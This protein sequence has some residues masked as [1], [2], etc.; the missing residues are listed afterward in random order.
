MGLRNR[1][2]TAA[3]AGA[4]ALGMVAGTAATATAHSGGSGGSGG[5]HDPDGQPDTRLSGRDRA[6]LRH[7]AEGA[8][9]E[10]A[11]GLFAAAAAV[12][13][14]VQALGAKIAADHTGELATV[15][16]L[17]AAYGVSLPGDMTSAQHDRLLQVA[18][19]PGLSFD[20]EYTELEVKVHRRNIAAFRSEARRG[21]N[22]D[23]QA[24]ARETIP[25]LKEH[26][27]AARAAN[28]VV[29]RQEHNTERP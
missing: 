27:D 14:E 3:A 17:A 22:D 7:A 2:L 15:M 9:F 11:A 21:R 5:N 23:V 1:L 24:F 19:E 12:T 10:I 16:A 29:E 26:L 13:P 28:E 25:E 18:A 8:Y 6:F 4:V 20:D